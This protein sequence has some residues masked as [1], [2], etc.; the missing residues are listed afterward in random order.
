MTIIIPK[1]SESKIVEPTKQDYQQLS[2]D[3]PDK[4]NIRLA[5][6]DEIKTFS[7]VDLSY[8][9]PIIK[10]GF[11]GN[12][13]SDLYAPTDEDCSRLGIENN[14]A[15]SQ[16][17]DVMLKSYSLE[18]GVAYVSDPH[19]SLVE[20]FAKS[21]AIASDVI[22][23]GIVNMKVFIK[24]AGIGNLVLTH[25]D[26][27]TSLKNHGSKFVDTLFPNYRKIMATIPDSS[28][29]GITSNGLE[30]ALY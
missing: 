8:G 16:E 4:K 27:G 18:D 26:V 12:K 19:G 23:N 10:K 7:G 14:Y 21:S 13:N 25:P 2:I 3:M 11:F 28:S 20:T 1:Y 9:V 24:D 6:L 5:S 15:V 22:K 30:Y 29:Q 17:G